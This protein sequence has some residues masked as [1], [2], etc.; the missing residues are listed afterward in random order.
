ML[1]SSLVSYRTF[2]VSRAARLRLF[3]YTQSA[4]SAHHV[5]EQF[6]VLPDICCQSRSA[7]TIILV[8][9]VRHVYTISKYCDMIS[10]LCKKLK[11]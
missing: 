2:V 3:S 7:S 8:H 11:P 6:S 9:A 1:K 5:K 10:V 4:T